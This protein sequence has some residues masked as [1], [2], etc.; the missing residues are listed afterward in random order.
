MVGFMKPKGSHPKAIIQLEAD[1][2]SC[3]TALGVLTER[4]DMVQLGLG[5]VRW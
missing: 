2:F 3:T 5:R 1:V 4:G